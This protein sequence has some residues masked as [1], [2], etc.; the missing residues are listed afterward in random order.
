MIGLQENGSEG[1][2]RDTLHYVY[3]LVKNGNVAFRENRMEEVSVLL[4]ILFLRGDGVL[5]MKYWLILIGKYHDC[6]E[7]TKLY[8]TGAKLFEDDKY[9]YNK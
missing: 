7:T 8:K 6:H 3:E 9:V 5:C 1:L 2:S 4:Y